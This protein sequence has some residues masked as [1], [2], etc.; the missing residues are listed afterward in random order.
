MVPSLRLFVSP[1]F[2]GAKSKKKE[3]DPRRDSHPN[4]IF[5]MEFNAVGP[6]RACRTAQN[7]L[8][9]D[10]ARVERGPCYVALM[11]FVLSFFSFLKNGLLPTKNDSL[12]FSR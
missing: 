1:L 10:R 6:C 2:L 8:G 12:G 9:A 11:S 4:P 5:A 3:E 7:A